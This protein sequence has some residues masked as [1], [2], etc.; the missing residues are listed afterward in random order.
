MSYNDLIKKWNQKVE[1]ITE[2]YSKEIKEYEKIGNN[3]NFQKIIKK[4]EELGKYKVELDKHTSL[5]SQMYGIKKIENEYIK[6]HFS[7]LDFYGFDTEF[8]MK[9]YLNGEKYNLDAYFDEE[10]IEY[11]MLKGGY[12]SFD[13]IKK[14]IDEV[15][16]RNEKNG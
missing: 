15:I 10:F 16:E 4:I 11:E 12:E 7:F 1:S 9:K 3:E 8:D 5:E 6:I 2:K 13:E 14:I